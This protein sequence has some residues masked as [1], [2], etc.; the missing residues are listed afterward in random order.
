MLPKMPQT[1]SGRFWFMF[2]L[3]GS[4]VIVGVVLSLAGAL[5]EPVRLGGFAV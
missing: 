1:A 4:L 2:L 5:N 3:L